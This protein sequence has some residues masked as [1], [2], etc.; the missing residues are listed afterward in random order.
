MPLV[1]LETL[2]NKQKNKL[3]FLRLNLRVL[4]ILGWDFH[5]V[6]IL[7]LRAIRVAWKEYHRSRTL[8]S[9]ICYYLELDNP[10]YHLCMKINKLILHHLQIPLK[11]QFSQANNAGT[12][13]SDAAILEITTDKGIKGYGEAC[14]R[15]YVTGESM[16]SMG[17]DVQKINTYL[18]SIA[19][20]SINGI[21][22]ILKHI[23][24][25][26]VGN[27]TICGLELA[28]LDALSKEQHQTI[29]DLLEIQ[30]LPQKLGYSLILPLVKSKYMAMLLSQLKHAGFSK[31]KLKVDQ[32]QQK[33]LENIQLVRQCF[34]EAIPIRVDV[35][36]GWTLEEAH[37]NI[38]ELM[39]KGRVYSF[40]Q[41]LDLENLLGLKVL[42]E[43]FGREARIMPDE[44][45]LSPQR[46]RELC[47]NK[48]G[49]H[50]NLKL[51]KIGGIFRCL[52]VYE[53][54]KQYGIPCQLGAHFAET[55]ILTHAGVLFS[56]MVDGL[57]AIEG[58]MGTN[59]LAYDLTD[60]PLQSNM[61]GLMDYDAWK[62]HFGWVD[63]VNEAVFN[64]V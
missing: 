56:A 34:G 49:N 48:M 7:S 22:N 59:L 3:T 4:G 53:T 25:L 41:P 43:K 37:K 60:K 8:S 42:T 13:T 29:A 40:E 27:S 14:P 2:A 30:Q 5:S 46:A 24:K 38:P 15:L 26:G 17:N 54:G 21:K 58:G 19:I 62:G 47:E 63:D 9:I 12:R 61:N 11:F 20:N 50:F 33:S 31:I 44:S 32:D 16:S 28:L 6:M 18:S 45:L 52:E 1:S 39:E 36:G 35:N 55:S 10:K 64:S 23:E 57:T 51:S